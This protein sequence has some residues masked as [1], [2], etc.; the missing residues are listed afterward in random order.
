[1]PPRARGHATCPGDR[2]GA[3][4]A[5]RLHAGRRR[6]GVTVGCAA[7]LLA[8][9]LLIASAGRAEGG[10][11]VTG[12]YDTERDDGWLEAADTT[13][14]P[15][16]WV[17]ESFTDKDQSNL[18]Y[19]NDTNLT[20]SFEDWMDESEAFRALSDMLDDREEQAVVNET[21]TEKSYR[22]VE[23]FIEEEDRDVANKVE[24]ENVD[25]STEIHSVVFPSGFR[26]TSGAPGADGIDGEN[27]R[28]G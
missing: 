9:L 18:L 13:V 17:N 3:G 1:M 26:G 23:D 20:M 10:Q 25:L 7:V 5:A 2:V 4:S 21:A 22:A 27:G 11:A 16:D 19:T 28:A 15:V 24:E 8:G 14:P 6:R 12:D